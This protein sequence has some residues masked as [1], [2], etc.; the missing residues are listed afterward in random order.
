MRRFILESTCTCQEKNDTIFSGMAKSKKQTAGLEIDLKHLRQYQA[1]VS[2]WVVKRRRDIEATMEF[3]PVMVDRN[4]QKPEAMVAYFDQLYRE[5]ADLCHEDYRVECEI[6][7]RE[8]WLHPRR[9]RGQGSRNKQPA[10]VDPTIATAI[11][12]WP[13]VAAQLA[14]R[15]EK[16]PSER[17]VARRLAFEVFPKSA[18]E[19]KDFAGRLRKAWR[20]RKSS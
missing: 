15:L 3:C 4:G 14:H 7:K 2:S 13:A 16:Q 1:E 8:S 5:H 10:P 11:L 19:R 12:K 17:E 18:S 6:Q 9:G 20:K